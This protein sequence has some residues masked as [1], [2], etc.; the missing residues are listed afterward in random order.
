MDE[1]FGFSPFH[2]Y[3]VSQPVL[4]WCCYVPHCLP[5]IIAMVRK[6]HWRW[7]HRDN[8]ANISEEYCWHCVS[9]CVLYLCLCVC[10]D[11]ADC[12]LSSSDIVAWLITYLQAWYIWHPTEVDSL[13][14]S[15]SILSSGIHMERN[16]LCPLGCIKISFIPVCKENQA[17]M[18]WSSAWLVSN[19]LIVAHV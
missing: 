10:R 1:I 5:L 19:N 17:P 12:G 16:L 4:L 2:L 13:L 8:W 18:R 15:S 7:T 11:L 9:R 14:P 3:S 6:G